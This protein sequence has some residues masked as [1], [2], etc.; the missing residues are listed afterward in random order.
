MARWLPG[1][2]DSFLFQKPPVLLGE[3]YLVHLNRFR[4]FT[5]QFSKSFNL[6]LKILSLVEGIPVK[7]VHPG[8]SIQQAKPSQLSLGIRTTSSQPKPGK[9]SHLDPRLCLLFGNINNSKWG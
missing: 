7:M 6:C 4:V 9:D 5:G 3:I 1:A 8:I 2:A